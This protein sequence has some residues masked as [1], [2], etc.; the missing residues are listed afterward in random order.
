[1][2]QPAS[3]P[4]PSSAWFLVGAT[5]VGKTAVAQH[6][7]EQT[8][9]AILSADA[10]LV[11]RGM[12]IGTAKPSPAERGAVRYLGI[13]LA[14][15]DE[16]FSAGAWLARVRAELSA[17]PP[18]PGMPASA[19]D[20]QRGPT[21]GSLIVAGGTGL[22]VRALAQGLDAPPADPARRQHWQDRLARE[23]VQALFREL[24]SRAPAAAA[25]LADPDNPRRVIR[26]LEQF[27]AHGAKPEA[28]RKA[29]L[30]R[31]VGLRL[32]RAALQARIA[33]RVERMFAAGLLDEVA[34]LRARFPAWRAH[35]HTSGSVR[36]APDSRTQDAR[37]EPP[38]SPGTSVPAESSAAA[39]AR[40]AIGYAEACDLLD[41]R[42]TRAQAVARIVVRTRQ[43]AKRQETWFRHQAEVAWIDISDDEPVG[44]VAARVLAVW[45]EHGPTPIR[46]S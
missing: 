40:Q 16:P 25:H 45:S 32:P 30:P 39:T 8:G 1:M 7:A 29:A 46:L 44:T 26:A 37:R 28:W 33:A 23:G 11:Y 6:L 43:L 27:E 22:Y 19:A 10:M 41:N 18:A 3:H 9:A 36:I 38:P 15:P 2:S 14:D 20:G 17:C 21:A 35:S 5:A 12:D 34:A 42:I 31:V 13:D 4:L 24:A